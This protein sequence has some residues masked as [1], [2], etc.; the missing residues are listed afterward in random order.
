MNASE[1]G[2]LW[3]YGGRLGSTGE[4]DLETVRDAILGTRRLGPAEAIVL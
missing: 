1:R 2:P 3:G 4:C